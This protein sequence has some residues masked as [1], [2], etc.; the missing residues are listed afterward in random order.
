MKLAEALMERADLQRRLVQI[1]ER[2]KQNALYQEGEIPAESV[3]ELLAA[4]RRC[5]GRLETL[6]V[7]INR[8][9]QQITLADGTPMLQALARRDGLIRECAMLIALCEAAMPDNSRYSR[10]ELRYVSAVNIAEI[11]KDADKIAQSC[12]QLDILV[13][14]ANWAHDLN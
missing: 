4:Y 7:A 2:I 10:S 1:R 5:A 14:Q 3:T 6:V 9:N 8:S 11:R 13:Q 12:R